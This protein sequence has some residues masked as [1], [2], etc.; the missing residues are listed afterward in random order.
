MVSYCLTSTGSA[1]WSFPTAA[2]PTRSADQLV[3]IVLIHALD[4]CSQQL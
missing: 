2:W 4:L 3:R 1:K